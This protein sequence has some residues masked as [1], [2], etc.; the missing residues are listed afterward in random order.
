MES[1]VLVEN[2]TPET[3]KD[4]TEV[5]DEVENPKTSDGIMI[6][7]GLLAVSIVTGFIA[8]EEIILIK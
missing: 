7:F 8:K 3:P 4:D 6:A 2:T 5:K 1:F